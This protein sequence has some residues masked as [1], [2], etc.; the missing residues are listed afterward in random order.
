M[1][2]ETRVRPKQLVIIAYQVICKR[3]Y[4]IAGRLYFL[5]NNPVIAPSLTKL[6]PYNINVGFRHSSKGIEGIGC[7]GFYMRAVEN[8]PIS[9]TEGDGFPKIALENI[10]LC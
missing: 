10:I 7:E 2:G 6:Y 3:Q 5:E 1:Q 8:I 9:N 4:R